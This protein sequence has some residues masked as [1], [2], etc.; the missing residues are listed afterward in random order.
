MNIVH[1]EISHPTGRWT[2]RID[3]TGT[4]VAVEC[5]GVPVDGFTW[6]PEAPFL[7][8]PERYEVP[9]FDPKLRSAAKALGL[10]VKDQLLAGGTPA[11][12][13]YTYAEVVERVGVASSAVVSVRA[14]TART[15]AP[16]I[17]GRP[18]LTAAGFLAGLRELVPSNPSYAA[19]LRGITVLVP[20]PDAAD[21]PDAV[22]IWTLMV[23]GARRQRDSAA[24]G[25]GPR[26]V[27]WSAVA[28][29]FERELQLLLAA[30]K[31]QARA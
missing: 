3:H 30:Q 15:I 28:D 26:V 18:N 29:D 10:A 14:N 21:L 9:D 13:L 24:T 12:M 19:M 5:E 6:K 16:L 11:A 22:A 8:P 23:E 27:R 4:Q 25:D 7:A 20:V 2:A 31:R 17:E 1:V